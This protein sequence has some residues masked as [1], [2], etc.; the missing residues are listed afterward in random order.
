MQTKTLF[1]PR[2]QKSHQNI[3]KFR[4]RNM[5]S[6]K[7]FV[8]LAVISAAT[9]ANAEDLNDE[10][11]L[12]EVHH[13]VNLLYQSG[14]NWQEVAESLQ[15]DANKFRLYCAFCPKICRKAVKNNI[16]NQEGRK[17]GYKVC[18]NACPGAGCP[19]QESTETE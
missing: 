2:T 3:G 5:R 11:L 12:K 6:F 1:C 16:E 19:G 9:C 13:E 10:E 17:K 8:A 18:K 4:V 7:V 15:E 14:K